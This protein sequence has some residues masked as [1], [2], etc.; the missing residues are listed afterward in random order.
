MLL[1]SSI[2][3]ADD[4]VGIDTPTVP[5]SCADA[6]SVNSSATAPTAVRMKWWRSMQVSFGVRKWT[7]IAALAA[8][9]QH[10][11]IEPSRGVE[12][13]GA[14]RGRQRHHRMARRFALDHAAFLHQR[15]GGE[16]A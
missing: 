15:L 16:Q 14:H 7:T 2:Q 11:R 13:T 6:L 12:Q 4:L 10:Q 3:R 8:P 5:L 9:A 1:P